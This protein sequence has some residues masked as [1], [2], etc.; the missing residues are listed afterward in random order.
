IA[1]VFGRSG[2]EDNALTMCLVLAADA[3]QRAVGEARLRS[4]LWSGFWVGAAFQTKMVQAWAVLPV[5]LIV[6]L[7]CAPAPSLR[8][9][10]HT[11]AALVFTVAV[12]LSDMIL[13]QLTPASDRPYVDGSASNNVFGMVFGYNFLDRFRSLGVSSGSTTQV[14]GSTDW[15]KLFESGFASQI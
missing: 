15:R 5:F 8:R 14:P 6:Y 11:G 13:V 12:S 2:M 10:W 4:L 9:L 3:W 7:V 1:A